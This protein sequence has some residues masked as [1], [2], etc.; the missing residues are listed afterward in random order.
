MSKKRKDIS[1][2]PEKKNKIGNLLPSSE[3]R[4]DAFE[5]YDSHL[6]SFESLF[7]EEDEEDDDDD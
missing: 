4:D 5:E 7:D 3:E 6:G 1:F 2:I